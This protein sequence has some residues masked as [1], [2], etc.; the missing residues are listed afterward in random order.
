[1]W[2]TGSV[3][4]IIPAYAGS[5]AS[6]SSGGA[7]Q[8]DHP[9]IRGEHEMTLHKNGLV[10]GSSP[11][12]RG[13]Q[14]WRPPTSPTRRIIPAYAGST[15]IVAAVGDDDVGSSPHT[16]GALVPARRIR[17]GERIIPAYA[18]STRKYQQDK[19]WRSGSSPHT[20]GAQVRYP[21]PGCRTRIIPAY[22]GSTHDVR[23]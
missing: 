2:A 6:T 16:R 10:V 15:R 5:T 1:M 3:P 11:H 22:A 20:R 12:T 23:H 4:G 21:W 19:A 14:L 17:Q 7:S 9:R 13:A 8:K 18:G